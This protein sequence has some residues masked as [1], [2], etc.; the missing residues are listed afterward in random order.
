MELTQVNWGVIIRIS[1]CAGVDILTLFT[2]LLM[3]TNNNNPGSHSFRSDL[4]HDFRIAYNFL[5][6]A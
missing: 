3:A 2:Q 6:Q 4:E 5:A 1:F